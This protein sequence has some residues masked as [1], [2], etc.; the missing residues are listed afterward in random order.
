MDKHICIHGHFYQ[1]PREN[2]WLEE[3]E[4]QDSAYPYH[5]WNSRIT[6]EC[7]AP[8]A[9]SRIL[10][11]ENK[12]IGIVNNYSHISFN[13]GPTLLSWMEIHYPDNY[14]HILNADTESRKTFSGHGSAI[15]QAYNH[16][17]MP[18]A[19]SRDKRTQVYWGIKDFEHRFNR[20]P[21]GM[22]LPETAVD[23]ETLDV[24]AD[25][26]I[27]FTILAPNQAKR[28]RTLTETAWKDITDS[29]IDP[30]QPYLCKL[31]SGR[32][33]TV[34][35]Y[36]GPISRDVAF[37]GSLDSGE[38]FAN[39]L[40]AAFPAELG[41]D[42]LENI[43]TDGETY[44]HHHAHGDMAL[45]YCLYH[46]K[47]NTLAKLTIYG[48]YLDNHSPQQEIEI[49]EN[50]SWS[51]AHG[52]E[53]WRSN[54]GCNSGMHPTWNQEWRAPLRGAL[55]WLRDNL[56]E[57]YEEHMP[58]FTDDIWKIRDA[59]IEVV[60]D[61]STDNVEN[62]FMSYCTRK[63]SQL[64]K[65]SV[66][67]L[68]EM[69][70]H[71]MLMYTSCAWFF[72]EISGIETV[73]VLTYAAR[74][75]QLAREMSTIA[76]EESFVKLL[77]MAPSNVPELSNGARIY[78]LFVKPSVIDLLLV[79]VHYAVASLF[80]AHK[81][82]DSDTIYHYQVQKEVYEK[83][84]AGKLKLIV[85]KI[86]VRSQITLEE[87]SISFAILHLGDMNIIGGARVFDE[88]EPFEKMLDE[89]KKVFTQGDI[90]EIIRH[91]NNNFNDHNFSLGH[92]FKDEQRAVI[93]TLLAQSENNIEQSFRQIY[94]LNFA[95]VSLMK[96]LKM[97]VPGY[98]S[99]IM[100]FLLTREVVHFF[101]KD[102][103]NFDVLE[104]VSGEIQKWNVAIDSAK[105]GYVA[106]NKINELTQNFSDSPEDPAILNKIVQI[107]KACGLLKLN[108]NLWKVQN[109]YYVVGKKYFPEIQSRAKNG[110][111]DAEVWVDLFKLLGDYLKVK[112]E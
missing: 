62:F 105:A 15:A 5:D 30:K 4:T 89:M 60:L 7:Y 72:D 34:F 31:P 6:A 96:S 95:N 112:I 45:A 46:I 18:L 57:I 50:S 33:M 101:N 108:V 97:P 12:I 37:G 17:I 109:A 107:L 10:S 23:V 94:E 74:A 53:R 35:I 21:E 20:K 55:D 86:V 52:V 27:R 70:R 1:P 39:K 26:G 104:K 68:L 103:L 64:E 88:K 69:Q 59:Y 38:N 93:N 98:F 85:G 76:L 80:A 110:N 66:L 77:E 58:A 49:Y 44:G 36:D 111:K 24:M 63:L 8:N 3:V 40:L 28:T 83:L 106:E 13:F 99:V 78:E 81:E 41:N 47:S 61:R 73:Q 71:A 65:V 11:P 2:A 32:T 43:A 19:N 16:L 82:S 90:S 14:K 51:C 22:W 42:M 56:I 84:E 92:L 25:C 91:I 29:A 102:M 9:A 87:Q 100:E 75:M 48:E 67:K 79:G 54:C